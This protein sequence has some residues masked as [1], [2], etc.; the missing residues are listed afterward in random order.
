MKYIPSP[1]GQCL[2]C[3]RWWHTFNGLTSGLYVHF[4]ITPAAESPF[5]FI[6]TNILDL[7]H[8]A[9]HGDNRKEWASFRC[10]T[11]GLVAARVRGS[12]LDVEV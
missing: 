4:V 8:T 6:P 12:R 3:I 2:V 10:Q 11:G 1:V 9:F 7:T 5:I